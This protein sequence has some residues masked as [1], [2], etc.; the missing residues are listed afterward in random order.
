MIHPTH[1]DQRSANP[2]HPIDILA[3]EKRSFE[4]FLD[5]LVVGF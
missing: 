2:F 1:H 5:V 4:V 3:V